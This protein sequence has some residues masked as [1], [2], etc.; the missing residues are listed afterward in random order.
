MTRDEILALFRAAFP[1]V[2]ATQLES[3]VDGALGRLQEGGL[4]LAQDS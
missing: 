1:D 2:P 4:L 3:D